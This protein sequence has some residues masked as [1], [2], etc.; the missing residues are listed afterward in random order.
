MGNQQSSQVPHRIT[1]R[2]VADGYTMTCLGDGYLKF[3]G[4]S[5]C[6]V[7]V[8]FCQ[9]LHVK[10]LNPFCSLRSDQDGR[11]SGNDSQREAST[12]RAPRLLFCFV[13]TVNVYVIR[14][15]DSKYP[16]YAYVYMKP[17][18]TLT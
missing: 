2:V 10:L 12:I 16:F 17:R 15:K 14:C 7:F 6:S 9:T 4:L 13:F 1:L 8:K 3:R 11:G 5:C 18:T